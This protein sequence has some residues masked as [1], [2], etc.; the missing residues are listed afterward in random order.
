MGGGNRCK[1]L[2]LD[3][4]SWGDFQ[5]GVVRSILGGWSRTSYVQGQSCDGGGWWGGGEE[6]VEKRSDE[7]DKNI[8]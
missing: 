4:C 3:A 1:R 7:L 6:R 2:L 8:R 5:G